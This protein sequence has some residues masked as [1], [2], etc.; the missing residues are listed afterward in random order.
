MLS[1]LRPFAA[2]FLAS[3][4][5]PTLA[6]P[7]AP[8]ANKLFTGVDLF[9]LSMASDPQISPDG[10]KLVYTRFTGNI[11]NDRFNPSLWLIDLR[12]GRQ[13][14]L[15][16]G[17]GVHMQA[18][19][20]P[21][22]SRIAY[23]ST[24]EGGAPQMF[25]R[26]LVSGATVRVTTL[27]ESPQSLAWSPDS[28]RIAYVMRVPGAGATLGASPPR[29]EGAKWADPL[30]VIDRVT[31]RADGAGNLKPGFNHV[32]VVD[33]E[34][35]APAQCSFGDFNDGGRLSWTPDGRR[36]LF[37]SVR[38]PDW[39]RE[40][41]DT[42]IY[43]VDV[44]GGNLTAL[45]KRHGPDNSPTV[46]PDGSQVAYLGYDDVNRSYEGVELYVMG[47][48]GANPHSL[49][50]KL[51]RSIDTA[52]W[53]KDGRALIASY[54]D[55]GQ[56]RVARIGLDG[57]V[58]KLADGLVGY[59][60]D[61]PY[62]GGDFSVANNGAIAYTGGDTLHPSDVWVTAG[63]KASRKT[64]LSDSLLGSKTL[65]QVR[66]V[67]VTGH[68]GR[69]IDAWLM[70]PPGYV[71]GTR[72][73]LILEI[74]GG[75]NSAYSS[76]FSTDFQLY[77]AAGY[78]VLYTNPRGS[79]SYGEGFAN[80]INRKYPGDDY[81]DLMTSVDA[82]IA[83]GIADPDRLFVTGGSGGGILT[84]WIVG[85]TDRFKAAAAQKSVVNW[86]SEALTMDDATFIS[87]YWFDKK[88][89]E[90]PMEYWSRSPMSVVGNIKTPTLVVV[91]SEDFRTPVSESEQLYTALQIRGVPTA[92]VKV[93]GAGHEDLAARPSQA[94]AKASAILAW[95]GKYGGTA[96]K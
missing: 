42:E 29:P 1:A 90:D 84:T 7:P 45:T 79:T 9:A 65:G 18:R 41:F 5:V 47:I 83:S 36:I 20:S 4:T 88:P 40:E 52:V 10:T 94:A 95:F 51:D 92:L 96:A 3:A 85:K 54:D 37:S 21:D 93:P 56:R 46:S 57:S 72:V 58:T 50:A 30:E 15:V 86:L 80:L 82:A 75:P 77:A 73:P 25:V 60:L 67:P 19:W 55:H 12:T 38:R 34:G 44:T 53:A 49:T 35:G 68:D 24:A 32:F 78:A 87:R 91:G 16:A 13:E 6:A 81:A 11:M 8:G 14:P 59:W 26:W 33:A 69:P 89:W 64:Q 39:E 43:A 23:I 17:T 2:L 28:K 48:D 76:M 62:A 63:G 74:H 27:S 22:G 31:Y 61:R 70:T 66:K 71:E